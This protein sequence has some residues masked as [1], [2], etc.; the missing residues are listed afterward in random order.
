MSGI[1]V[2][3]LVAKSTL[4]PGADKQITTESRITIVNNIYLFIINFL[5]FLYFVGLLIISEKMI[6][7][8]V[9]TQFAL[10]TQKK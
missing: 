9:L 7:V 5:E 4:L 10:V 6:A 2:I 1:H 3:V 8:I